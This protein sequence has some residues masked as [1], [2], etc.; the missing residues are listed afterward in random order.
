MKSVL[1]AAKAA[2]GM[3]AARAAEEQLLMSD[4]VDLLLDR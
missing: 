3:L 1:I 4:P 2:L